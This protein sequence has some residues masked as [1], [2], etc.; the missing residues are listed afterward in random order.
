MA[1]KTIL[2]VCV[3]NT[4]RSVLSEELFN[5]K[6]P[7]GW[8]AESAGVSPSASVNPHVRQ[9]LSETGITLTERTP[10]VVTPALV[11]D[12]SRV[13]TF[14]CLDRC[15][16]GAGDK[17]EDWALPGATGK[18]FEEL[19][20]IRDE[21]SNRVDDLISRLRL[22]DQGVTGAPRARDPAAEDLRRELLRKARVRETLTYG[23]MMRILGISRGH[24][25]F[26]AISA[27]DREEYSRG[28]PGFAAIIVRKDT[29]FP[30]G[31]FFCDD[32][33]PSSLR[34]P[35]SRASDPKLSAAE[36]NHVKE[37]QKKIWDY[38]SGAQA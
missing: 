32:S 3:E 20:G 30:G 31:G 13:V 37:E 12:A 38:Y 24:P 17:G 33:L 34:R 23:E 22:Q 11:A 26:E 1:T 18:T 9:L 35:I 29:G 28:A 10:R 19:R 16:I 2:F 4:F 8:R 6:A 36:M 5:S 21:L 15:P 14:G 27:V 7:P 25:L